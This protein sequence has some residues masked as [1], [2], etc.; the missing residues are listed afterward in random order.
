MFDINYFKEHVKEELDDAK[1]YIDAAIEAKINYPAWVY[2]L[3][4][5]AD[6]EAEH[7]GHLMGM[8]ETCIRNKTLTSTSQDPA[9]AQANPETVYKDLMKH[10][11]ETM[12]YVINMK[13]GL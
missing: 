7:A 10:Y 5:M 3:V 9:L 12:T 6:N 11:G 13:R 2:Y 1:G 8:F 4:K